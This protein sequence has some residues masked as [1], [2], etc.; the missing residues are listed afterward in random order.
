[1]VERFMKEAAGADSVSPLT[2]TEWQ[3]RSGLRGPANI[4]ENV[5]FLF[6]PG[7]ESCLASDASHPCVSC[8]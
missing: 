6:S 7:E 3:H 4:F 5:V 8:L 2:E 1:M